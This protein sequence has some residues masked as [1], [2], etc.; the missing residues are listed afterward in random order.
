VTP[1]RSDPN[2]RSERSYELLP[3]TWG[4]FVLVIVLAVVAVA[5]VF[6]GRT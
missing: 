6:V 1:A 4:F 5:L 2:S 3:V